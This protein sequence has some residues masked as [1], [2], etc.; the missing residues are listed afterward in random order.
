[1]SI[2]EV[3]IE[4]RPME[5]LRVKNVIRG[6]AYEKDLKIKFGDEMEGGSAIPC[7]TST[8]NIN[9]KILIK[10][11]HDKSQVIEEFMDWVKK[12]WK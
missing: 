4:L 3:T 8:G 2:K 5:I 6:N 1:M 9:L 10:N 7:S 12:N 11:E